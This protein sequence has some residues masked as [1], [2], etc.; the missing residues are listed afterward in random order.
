[1]EVDHATQ[2]KERLRKQVETFKMLYAEAELQRRHLQEKNSKYR[3]IIIK[4]GKNDDE[5][6]DHV[7]IKYF[8]DL[9]EQIQKIAQKEYTK[10]SANLDSQTNPLSDQQK[11]FFG[12]PL[13]S[14]EVLRSTRIFS[15]RSQLFKFLR[16][17]FFQSASFGMDAKMEAHLADFEAAI[18][19]CRKGQPSKKERPLLVRD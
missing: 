2:E 11:A 3:D 13:M 16:E 6:L 8:C 14:P 4:S 5:P 15:I 1:M 18:K 7:V 9:R 19:S 17:F 10:H 12:G